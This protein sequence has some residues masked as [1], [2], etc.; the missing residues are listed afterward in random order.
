MTWSP[1]N[2]PPAGITPPDVLVERAIETNGAA[3]RTQKH[4]WVPQ[5]DVQTPYYMGFTKTIHQ[6]DGQ[7]MDADVGLEGVAPPP[8]APVGDRR[9]RATGMKDVSPQGPA[10][11]HR[12]NVQ[13]TATHAETTGEDPAPLFTHGQ[14]TGRS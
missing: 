11:A 5:Q 10:P 6:Y 3:Y 4:A 14:V 1:P 12:T 7:T 8:D 2:S 9:P 13:N